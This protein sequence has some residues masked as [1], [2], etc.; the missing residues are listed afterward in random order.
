M[1]LSKKQKKLVNIII[2]VSTLALVLT[3][4]LSLLSAIF[5]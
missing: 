5:R 2:V 4:I 1:K 3:P